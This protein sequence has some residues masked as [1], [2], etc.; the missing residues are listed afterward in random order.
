M[1]IDD[2]VLSRGR[3]GHWGLSGM[4]E[5]ANKIGAQLNIWSNSGAGTEIEL[6]VPANVAFL[7]NA[8]QTVWQRIT[9]AVKR[10]REAAQWR[11]G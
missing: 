11:K 3:T 1:G 6:T 2:G 4:R 7:S 5:R 10:P 8:A 9:R